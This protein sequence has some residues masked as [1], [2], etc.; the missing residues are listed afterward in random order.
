MNI[1]T[2]QSGTILTQLDFPR[3]YR[4]GLN[5]QNPERDLPVKLPHAV[6]LREHLTNHFE[7]PH[8]HNRSFTCFSLLTLVRLGLWAG[9][10]SLAEIQHYGQF[11]TPRPRQ[12]LEWP[13]RTSRRK[14]PSYNP[15]RNLL[16]KIDPE[17]LSQAVHP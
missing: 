10:S 7:D 4:A 15:L 3:Q 9:R 16:I 13:V 1:N 2:D 14:A 8:R 5:L 17:H 11:L 6:L 12:L